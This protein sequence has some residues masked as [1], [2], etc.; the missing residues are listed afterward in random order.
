MRFRT[1]AVMAYFGLFPAIMSGLV[2]YFCNSNFSFRLLGGLRPEGLCLPML[3]A[4]GV[5]Y[6]SR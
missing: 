6:R 3:N 4:C 1:T 2:A 5:G